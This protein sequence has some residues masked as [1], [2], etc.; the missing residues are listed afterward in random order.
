MNACTVETNAVLEVVDL[1]DCV[2]PYS[3][4]ATIAQNYVGTSSF[5]IDFRITFKVI[6]ENQIH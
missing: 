2:S 6:Q 5:R 1:G 4:R 3:D